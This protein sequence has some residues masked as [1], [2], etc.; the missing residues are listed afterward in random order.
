MQKIFRMRVFF[1]L[2]ALVALT[3]PMQQA[4]AQT[5]QSA[6]PQPLTQEET[7]Q[8]KGQ[9]SPKAEQTVVGDEVVHIVHDRSDAAD[10]AAG[11]IIVF[12]FLLILAAAAAP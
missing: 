6:Q 9:E 1:I 5:V 7:I 12:F 3:L 10:F 2:A 8:L 11:F 4:E